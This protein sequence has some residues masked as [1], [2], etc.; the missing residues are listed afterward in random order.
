MKF[1]LMGQKQKNCILSKLPTDLL[2]EIYN[3]CT[4]DALVSHVL[5]NR[6][7]LYSFNKYGKPDIK[8][9]TYYFSN[10][11]SRNNFSKYDDNSHWANDLIKTQKL[12][13]Y[14]EN[15]YKLEPFDK[16]WINFDD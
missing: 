11:K 5:I 13:Y 10:E 7:I 1:I 4:Y 16:E 12:V 8:Y 14:K 2:K 9:Y 3:Y 6:A 15:K